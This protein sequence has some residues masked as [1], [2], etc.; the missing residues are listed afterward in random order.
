MDN[1]PAQ[2]T[3]EDEIQPDDSASNVTGATHTSTMWVKAAQERAA[4]ESNVQYLQQKLELEQTLAEIDNEEEDARLREAELEFEE[5]QH[6]QALAAQ[7]ARE[8]QELARRKQR[9]AL[10]EAKMKAERERRRRRAEISMREIKALQ[11]MDAARR[12][13][14]MVAEQMNRSVSTVSQS[15]TRRR[16]TSSAVFHDAS[17]VLQTRQDLRH[18]TVA[19]EDQID[20]D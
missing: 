11:R 3:V 13:E 7:Q 12:N 1:D 17:D 4:A 18:E 5:D 6:R 2:T 19:E 14:E 10:E 8:E 9:Q 15:T 20:R 16:S